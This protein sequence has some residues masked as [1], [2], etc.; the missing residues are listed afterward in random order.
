MKV[1]HIKDSKDAHKPYYIGRANKYQKE[2][3]LHNPFRKSDYKGSRVVSVYLYLEHLLKQIIDGDKAVVEVFSKKI[4]ISSTLVCYCAPELCHGEA[5]RFV[6]EILEYGEPFPILSFHESR[7]KQLMDI[8]A[9]VFTWIQ[10]SVLSAMP[11]EA[12]PEE[13]VKNKRAT[14]Y[15]IKDSKLTEISYVL[16]LEDKN[17]VKKAMNFANRFLEKPEYKLELKDFFINGTV[18]R[19]LCEDDGITH[20]NIY[21][22]AKTSLGRDLSHFSNIGF[23]LDDLSFASIEGFWYWL[24]TG[25]KHDALRYLTGY[26]AKTAGKACVLEHGRVKIDDEEFRRQIKRANVAKISQTPSLLYE[27]AQKPNLPFEHYYVYNDNCI[28]LPEYAWIVKIFEDVRNIIQ[29]NDVDGI[30]PYVLQCWERQNELST[31]SKENK[32]RITVSGSRS[33][34]DYGLFAKEFGR[35]M[36]RSN[37]KKQ[38]IVVNVGGARG[39]DSLAENYCK[40]NGIELKLYLAQWDKYP[41]QAGMIRNEEMKQNTDELFALHDGVSRGTQHMIDICRKSAIPVSLV[42]RHEED[43]VTVWVGF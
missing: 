14:M 4:D 19:P 33:I 41:R 12:T 1:I 35:F 30:D 24:T 11:A 25:K 5:I 40:E 23:V 20:I 3:P 9:F 28:M 37:L 31:S 29:H 21:S 18:I 7:I 6:Y 17:L 34:K 13:I 2:S 43:D 22:K 8:C 16:S 36:S 39:V 42:I 26:A 15:L 10:A 27:L 32:K 38:D